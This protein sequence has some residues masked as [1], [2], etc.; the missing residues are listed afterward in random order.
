MWEGLV[1]FFD[2]GFDCFGYRDCILCF[3]GFNWYLNGVNIVVFKV[4]FVFGKIIFNI[5]DIIKGYFCVCIVDNDG[6][7]WK[8]IVM[9]IL[10]FD[11]YRN[12]FRFCV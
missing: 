4:V 5:G 10:V 8:F 1:F 7:C 11:L 9:V 12:N 6:N 3:G 2:I